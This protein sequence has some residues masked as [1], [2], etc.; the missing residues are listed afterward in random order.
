MSGTQEAV[1]YI[2]ATCPNMGS[3]CGK[4]DEVDKFLMRVVHDMETSKPTTLFPDRYKEHVAYALNMVANHSFTDPPAAIASVYLATRFEFYFR[5][6]SGKL[7][8]DGTW[9]TSEA[10]STA[11]AAI[12]DGRV[13][14]SRV[15]N[16]ALAYKVMKLDQSQTAGQAFNQLDKALF[17]I[18]PKVGAPKA[19]A[20]IGDRIAYLRHRVGHGEW[21][22]ISAESKFYGLVTAIVFYN[23]V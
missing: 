8:A 22:D 14:V 3:F 11:K 18:P 13:D 7:N 10:R 20:N 21:G 6:L 12:K 19:I 23:Q 2:I 16:V 4:E 5:I 9:I 15:S 17:P 1:D